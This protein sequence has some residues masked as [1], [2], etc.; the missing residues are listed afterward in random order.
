MTASPVTQGATPGS[1][2]D[3]WTE[4]WATGVPH[5]CGGSY[6]GEYGGEIRRFWAG[7]FE[8]LA[9]D[10]RV[11]DVCCGN[12]ALA[13]LLAS[14]GPFEGSG[15]TMDAVDAASVAP[16]WLDTLGQRERARLRFHSG[17]D[18]GRLPFPDGGFDLCTSQYGVEYAGPGAWSE[19]GRVLAPG[20]RFAA[21][22]HH[23]DSLPVR[24]AREECGHLGWL[25]GVDGPL[26]ATRS[27]L[28]WMEM[29]AAP[30]G[31]ER[32]NGD[33]LAMTARRVFRT[34]MQALD[35]RAACARWPD[36]LD[37][38]RPP[39]F[40][41]LQAARDRGADAATEGLEQACAQW[42]RQALR[43]TDLVEVAMDR[44]ALVALAQRVS[45]EPPRIGEVRFETG[46]VAGWSIEVR[47][48]D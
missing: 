25:L 9:E 48:G 15:V 2:S 29:A 30:G 6:A 7:T 36:V 22:V 20:G 23:A 33:A 38:A 5:S 19:V 24:I 41:A 13:R 34:A 31:V 32:L 45:G 39:L 43:A 47:R 10:A 44:E 18:A 35:E 42:S 21:I 16:A 27:L 8:G 28:P 46:D 12:G 1:R 4:Y 11:L 40:D 26:A 14:S 3:A 37:E 17:V